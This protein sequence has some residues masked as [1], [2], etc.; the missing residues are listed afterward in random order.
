MVRGGLM[1]KIGLILNNFDRY[2]RQQQIFE[3]LFKTNKSI[4]EFFVSKI[5]ILLV[6]ILE[7]S[8]FLQILMIKIFQVIGKIFCYVKVLFLMKINLLYCQ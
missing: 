5:L 1:G 4:N 8:S 3:V 2:S 6:D 7:I